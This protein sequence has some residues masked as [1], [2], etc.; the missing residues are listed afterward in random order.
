M[1]PRKAILPTDGRPAPYQVWFRY[2][3]PATPPAINLATFPD[4]FKAWWRSIQ[5]PER[6][7]EGI[8]RPLAFSSEAWARVRKAT[9]SG[10]YLVI[11][12]LMWWRKAIATAGNGGRE[13]RDWQ[14][15]VD[16][17]AWSVAVW[18]SG[19][20]PAAPSVSSSKSKRTSTLE[21]PTAASPPS[22]PSTPP[23]KR[24]HA[25]TRVPLR[26]TKRRLQ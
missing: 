10:F 4:E 9:Q 11:I 15:I 25:S 18:D 20:G 12:G 22:T 14:K 3:R 5:P 13:L 19:C 7:S 1:A 26:R 16:D 8:G 2:G 21:L 24:K 6:G 17:V 23:G